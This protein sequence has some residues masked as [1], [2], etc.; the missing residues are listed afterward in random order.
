MDRAASRTST[1]K[2]P[3]EAKPSKKSSVSDEHKHQ[4]A[5]T[6]SRV[7]T[8]LDLVRVL[9][10]YHSISYEKRISVLKKVGEMIENYS[11]RTMKPFG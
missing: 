7:Y 6:I 10:L 5:S 3:F 11:S 1:G 2:A 9:T 8:A 4:H